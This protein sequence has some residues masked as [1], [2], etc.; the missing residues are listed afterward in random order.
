MPRKGSAKVLRFFSLGS[1]EAPDYFFVGAFFLLL[2]I[3]I[4]MLSSASA[5]LSYQKFGTP[6]YYTI[7]QLLFGL[8]PGLVLLYITS[9]VDY[10]VWRTVALPFLLASIVLLVLVFL[11]GI[12]YEYGGARR[13]IHLGP[14]LFQP[15]EVVKLSLLLYLATWLSAKGAKHVQNF[16]YGFLPFA[17]M[18]G[19]IAVLVILQPDVG[20]MGVISAIAFTMY[21]IGGA[22]VPHLALAGAAGIA[23]IFVLI[24]TAEYRFRRF[25]TFLQPELD[26]LGTGYHINQALLA[27]GSGGLFGRGF[28][29]SRQKFAYLP[30]VTGDSIFAIVAEEMGFL[31]VIFFIALFVFIA[32]RG[33]RIARNAPDDFGRLVAVGI[34]AWIIFQAFINIA[35][36]LSLLPLTGIPLPFVSYGGSAMLVSLAAVG[37][38]INISRQGR[39]V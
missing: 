6:Y 30:E 10:H 16:A 26:P 25:M 28:G 9:R 34:V 32:V 23:M 35:A 20:T 2:T 8:L 36:M 21:F 15:S 22:A 17:V 5:V 37:I 4:V 39:K 11:P 7:H 27:I 18:I 3:G 33:L 1:S 31:F 29:H 24:Q 19:A 12:G 13:W 38:L 14:L